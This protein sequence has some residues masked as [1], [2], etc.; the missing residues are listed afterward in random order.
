MKYGRG[1]NSTTLTSTEVVAT[2]LEEWRS[3]GVQMCSKREISR[4]LG[5]PI[6]TLHTQV[7]KN[8]QKN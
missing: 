1:M 2:P 4:F 5:M 3:S 6:N 7:K 8:Q